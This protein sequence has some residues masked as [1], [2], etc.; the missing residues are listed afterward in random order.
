MRRP[1]SIVIALLATAAAAASGA[2]V[3]ADAACSSGRLMGVRAEL[4][5]LA[6]PRADTVL[7]GPGEF[8]YGQE[9]GA[10]PLSTIHGQRFRLDRVGGDVPAAL[11]GAEGG[12]AVLVPY[13]SQC[14]EVWRWN[15][16]RWAEPGT[17]VFADAVLRP[18]E[19]W[20][21]GRPTFDVDMV[22]D[23]YP[24][25]YK[26]YRDSVPDSKLSPA[27][28][29]GLNQALPT[30]NQ[31]Q[32]DTA[33]AYRRLNAWVRANPAMAARFP[34]NLTV[35]EAR[36]ML[37]PCVPAYDPHPV[38]GTY[39]AQVVVEQR[40]TIALHFR[41]DPRGYPLCGDAPDDVPLDAVRPRRAPTARLYVYAAADVAG[42]AAAERAGGRA[43]GCGVAII[44]VLNQPTGSERRPREWRAEYNYLALPSCFPDH[45][46]VG[47]AAEALFQA[48]VAGERHQAPGTFREDPAGGVRFEQAWR[49]NGRVVLELRATRT[50]TQAAGAVD[51]R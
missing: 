18:R 44:D 37:Q 13:G 7:A 19:Q 23:V 15:K 3:A 22:H 39:R 4:F 11:A 41:T 46:Q 29:F 26:R 32:A 2:R 17:Q 14:R 10:P 36:E 31:L 43:S 33:E 24:E 45:P 20:V 9:R 16:A 40:D 30:W 27:E 42:V 5:V 6:T 28:V 35:Q 47:E 38:A 8:N 25:S 34:A 49:A 1:A 21:N 12:E 50:G 51:A 48:Y